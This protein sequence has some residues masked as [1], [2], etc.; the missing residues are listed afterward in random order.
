MAKTVKE[1]KEL[2]KLVVERFDTMLATQLKLI[3]EEKGV[4]VASVEKKA[5]LK[6]GAISKWNVSSPT[7]K[8]IQAV[9]NHLGTTVEQL[10][11]N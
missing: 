6:S 9:A 11:K 2:A 7:V 1:A 8:S 5:G 3:A 10:I 4:S